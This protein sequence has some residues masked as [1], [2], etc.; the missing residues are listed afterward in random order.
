MSE[1]GGKRTFGVIGWNVSYALP[2]QP[3]DATRSLNFSAGEK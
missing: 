1:K 3:I 2:I